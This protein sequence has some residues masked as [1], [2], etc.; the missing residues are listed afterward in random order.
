MTHTDKPYHP[1]R[2]V[3]VNVYHCAEAEE[4]RR[5]VAFFTGARLEIYFP[6]ATHQQAYERA[7]AWRDSAVEKNE[8][9]YLER[10]ATAEKRRKQRASKNVE[11]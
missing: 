2:D 4:A 7:V 6:A 1:L 11:I 5:Y 10:L 8:A 9:T 3:G